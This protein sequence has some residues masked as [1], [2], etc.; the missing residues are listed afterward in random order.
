[1]NTTLGELRAT[2][3][4]DSSDRLE[5]AAVSG[6]NGVSIASS[7]ADEP[8]KKVTWNSGTETY[9]YSAWTFFQANKFLIPALIETAIGDAKGG[10]AFD[11]YS[12]VGL[13][14]L[15]LATAL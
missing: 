13:F 12:G 2:I 8:P 5:I 14:T 1:M 7:E 6:D 9:S 10:I 15:P 11:L 4:P 3:N